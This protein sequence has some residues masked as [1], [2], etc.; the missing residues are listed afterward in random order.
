MP[1]A[2]LDPRIAFL[3]GQLRPVAELCG[4]DEVETLI[5]HFGGMRVYVP[6]VVVS[7]AIARKCGAGVAGAL[8]QCY[9]GDYVVV[10]L[11]R[12]LAKARKHD[13]IRRDTRPASV[14]ARE[15]RMSVNSVYRIR[16]QAEAV[17]TPTAPVPRRTRPDLGIMDI[18]EVIAR[19]ARKA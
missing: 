18:E 3:P 5:E 6:S 8:R 10:P 15:W 7:A 11:A 2:D 9:G 17:A 12:T 1:K 4:F 16:G 13:A 14:I 19:Q